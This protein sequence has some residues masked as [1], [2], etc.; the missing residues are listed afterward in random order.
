MRTFHFIAIKKPETALF[1]TRSR[2]RRFDDAMVVQV[3]A[4]TVEEAFAIVSPRAEENGYRVPAVGSK[5]FQTPG[6]ERLSIFALD[7]AFPPL[8]PKDSLPHHLDED[9][10]VVFGKP[11]TFERAGDWD[12]PIVGITFKGEDLSL[13]RLGM[14]VLPDGAGTIEENY[15]LDYQGEQVFLR[16][17]RTESSVS[18]VGRLSS[19]G[20]TPDSGR[21]ANLGK[22]E[23]GLASAIMA[24]VIYARTKDMDAVRQVP[25]SAFD[26]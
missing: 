11:D 4:E 15:V 12:A 10:S 23:A 2:R 21:F 24:A 6:D 20:F 1:T 22:S 8:L 7:D 13:K 25:L 17:R 18:I 19:E 3:D 14:S 9:A 5:L 26:F 16:M